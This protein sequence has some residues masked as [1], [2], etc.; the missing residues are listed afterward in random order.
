M[1]AKR[2]QGKRKITSFNYYFINENSPKELIAKYIPI[3]GNQLPV[4]INEVSAA[5]DIF[6]D[7]FFKHSDCIELYN[8]TDHAVSVSGMYLSNDPD[9]PTLFRIPE[10]DSL[11]AYGFKVIWCDGKEGTTGIHA[12]FKLKNAE[13]TLV[14]SAPDRSWA[15]TLRYSMHE[16]IQ[17]IGLYP[18]GGK[19]LYVMNRP[20]IGAANFR[21]WFDITEKESRVLTGYVPVKSDTGN[22]RIYNLLGMP[23][24]TPVHGQMYIRDGKKFF[25]R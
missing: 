6:T 7:E 11:P 12:P 3:A 25:Y 15:D 10:T 17:S 5:N 24:H 4:R 14:L 19:K 8:P 23:V 2:Q 21:S 22:S 20:T 13:S 1:I 18:D 9:N 16:G